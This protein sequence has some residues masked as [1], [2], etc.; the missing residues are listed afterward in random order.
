MRSKGWK[1][2]EMYLIGKTSVMIYSTQRSSIQLL[3]KWNYFTYIKCQ[4][5]IA[6]CPVSEKGGGRNKNTYSYLSYINN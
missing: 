1:I 2:T 5:V 6:C 3:K 4:S